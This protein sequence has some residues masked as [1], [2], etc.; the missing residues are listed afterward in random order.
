MELIG[1]ETICC[2]KITCNMMCSLN[3]ERVIMNNFIEFS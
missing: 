1:I 2:Y 3:E